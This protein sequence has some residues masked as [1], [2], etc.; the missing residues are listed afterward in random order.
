MEIHL[1]RQRNVKKQLREHLGHVDP[2]TT[3]LPQPS[4]ATRS[5]ENW[6]M[7][8][9]VIEFRR[10]PRKLGEHL[11]ALP[12]EIGRNIGWRMER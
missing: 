9:C 4:S 3:A 1:A 12:K 10:P 11:R 2:A 8:R 5:K 6:S 7:K